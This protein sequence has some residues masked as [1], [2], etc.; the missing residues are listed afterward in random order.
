MLDVLQAPS[1]RPLTYTQFLIFVNDYTDEFDFKNEFFVENQITSSKDLTNV[2]VKWST[3]ENIYEKYMLK[4]VNYK[5]DE[6]KSKWQVDSSNELGQLIKENFL[7]TRKI[8]DEIRKLENQLRQYIPRREDRE[9]IIQTIEIYTNKKQKIEDEIEIME[10]DLE[11]WR[12]YE[13]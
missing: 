3:Y 9:D 12:N 5:I 2:G 11:E 8:E 10:R 7:A 6:I 13:K 1:N 4:W